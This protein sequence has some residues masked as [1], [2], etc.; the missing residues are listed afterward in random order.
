MEFIKGV[1]KLSSLLFFCYF[2]VS[3]RSLKD[4]MEVRGALFGGTH[5]PFLQ[6]LFLPLFF[7][8]IFSPLL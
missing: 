3:A 6:H 5:F 8:F 2:Y 1:S 4:R 7:F